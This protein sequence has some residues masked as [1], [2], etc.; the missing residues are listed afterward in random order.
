MSIVRGDFT[1]LKVAQVQ[2]NRIRLPDGRTID[3]TTTSS[4][5]LGSIYVEPKP[6][7]PKH[8]KTDKRTGP[9]RKSFARLKTIAKQKAES[10]ANGRTRGLFALV[11]A[12]DRKEW[13][14]Q[15][16]CSKIPYHPQWYP[17]GAR[18]D[19]L[20]EQPVDFGSVQVPRS[21]IGEAK[22][23]PANEQ[24]ADLRLSETISSADASAGDPIHAV[25]EEPV[26]SADHHLILP[27]GTDFTGK[28]TL[29]KRARLF[30]RGG[31]LRF[32]F[33]QIKTPPELTDLIAA[34]QRTH[35]QLDAVEQ[36]STKVAVD[37]EGT[38]KAMESKTRFLRPL[39]A[40]LV[41]AKSLDND[42]GKV[43]ANAGASANY[44]GRSLGGFSGFG[45][46]GTLAVKAPKPVGSALGLYGLAWSAYSTVVSRGRDVVFEKDAAIEIRFSDR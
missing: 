20:L 18:F 21:E 41:A 1:P 7:K 27:E 6:P 31:K 2:F 17:R 34:N 4:A 5:G 23:G 3:I 40:G 43:H 11:H 42:A 33:N 9:S 28:V 32:T 35:A 45:L 44:S 14:E 39:V 15:F 29:A 26:F 19:A 13:I 10:V 16:L 37:T 46:F 38:A 8:G 24:T 25:L 22:A 30:H 12:P 36:K